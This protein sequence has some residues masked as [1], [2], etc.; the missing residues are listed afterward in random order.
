M[1]TMISTY[2]IVRSRQKNDHNH[3]W[4]YRNVLAMIEHNE[5]IGGARTQRVLQVL[6]PSEN[7]TWIIVMV[8]GKFKVNVRIRTIDLY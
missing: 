3:R 6:H 4:N 2:G 7:L 5:F 1:R 8:D